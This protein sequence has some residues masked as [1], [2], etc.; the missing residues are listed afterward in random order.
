[1][2]VE[3]LVRDRL[4]RVISAG[5]AVVEDVEPVYPAHYAVR[6]YG[7]VEYVG[8]VAV[9]APRRT[10]RQRELL[11][12]GRRMYRI[13]ADIASERAL[14]GV[15]AAHAVLT[16]SDDV[17]LG[18]RPRFVGEI[19]VYPLLNVVRARFFEL[20]CKYTADKVIDLVGGIF[21]ACGSY[22]YERERQYEHCRPRHQ[23]SQSFSSH[24]SFS[25]RMLQIRLFRGERAILPRLCRQSWV[26]LFLRL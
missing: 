8:D 14:V 10:Q 5:V 23:P 16:E 11:A 20:I 22:R 12:G 18:H 7:A 3:E 4:R 26:T 2:Q 24:A 9:G 6:T 25:A 17:P 1:M 19:A 15:H 21:I 13:R